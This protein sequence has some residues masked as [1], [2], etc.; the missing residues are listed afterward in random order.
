MVET[1][2]YELAE[3]FSA[4]TKDGLEMVAVESWLDHAAPHNMYRCAGEDSWVAIACESDAQWLQLIAALRIDSLRDRKFATLTG[5]LA[6][7]EALDELLAASLARRD[8]AEVFETL[9][10]A[11]VPCSRV[12]SARDLV[13]DDH[14][15]ARSLFQK[16][17]HPHWGKRALTGLPWR[18]VG[19]GVIPLRRTPLLGEHTSED[20]QEWWLP[21]A[22][23]PR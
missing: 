3:Y 12:M 19:S 5:R 18:V 10:S 16:V 8:A 4:F 21:S 6:N 2:A 23:P 14:L 11:D 13:T 7:Q 22:Q 20:P 9:Q 1:V 15:R 17:D